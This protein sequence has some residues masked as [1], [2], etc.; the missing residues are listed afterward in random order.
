MPPRL[1]LDALPLDINIV[2]LRHIGNADDLGNAIRTTR[3]LWVAFWSSRKHILREV[4]LNAIEADG[5]D[6]AAVG[7]LNAALAVVRFPWPP[8]ARP[9]DAR[10]PA[11]GRGGPPG[12]LLGGAPPAL[13][14]GRSR[15]D[16]AAATPEPDRGRVRARLRQ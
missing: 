12:G 1:L 6:D 11:R 3:G 15:R 10:P 8:D 16:R 4:V 14:G 7:T 2:I 13:A 5:A 9:P